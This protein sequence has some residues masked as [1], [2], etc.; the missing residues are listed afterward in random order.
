[1]GDWQL[2][3]EGDLKEAKNGA[4]LVGSARRGSWGQMSRT[5]SNTAGARG[6]VHKALPGLGR[7]GSL[8]AEESP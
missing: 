7:Q 4:S 6:R 3:G 8:G 2:R 5:C 1:M